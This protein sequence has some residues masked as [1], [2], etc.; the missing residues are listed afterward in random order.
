MPLHLISGRA[1]AGKS[2]VAYARL[3]DAVAAGSQAILVLPTM[4]DVIR[5]RREFAKSTPLGLAVSTFPSLV[6]SLWGEWGDGRVVKGGGYRTLALSSLAESLGVKRSLVPLASQSV[7]AVVDTAGLSWRAEPGRVPSVGT[8]LARLM[9]A[10]AKNKI[11]AFQ[12]KEQLST[13]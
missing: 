3:R 11:L 7:Q 6:S 1:N 10:Y 2:G 8:E 4:P 13:H 9:R 5:A 12:E